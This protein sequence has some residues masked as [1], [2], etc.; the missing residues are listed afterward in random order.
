M[1][2]GWTM[3]SPAKESTDRRFLIEEAM[4]QI[5]DGDSRFAEIF[6]HGSLRLEIYAPRSRDP[7]QPHKQ[8]EIYFVVKGE[9]IFVNGETRQPFGPGDVMFAAAG[10][11]HRFEDFTDDFYTWVIFYGPDGGEK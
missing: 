9:G 3:V 11:V 8:D 1:K 6:R 10:E 4:K 2:E 7:Q 5:P